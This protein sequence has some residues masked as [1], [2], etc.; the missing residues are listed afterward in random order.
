MGN[1]PDRGCDKPA[2]KLTDEHVDGL[3]A[4]L[5]DYHWWLELGRKLKV[6]LLGVIAIP[7]VVLGVQEVMRWLK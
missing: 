6:L 4:M 1:K 7:A 3:L 5:T 2:A